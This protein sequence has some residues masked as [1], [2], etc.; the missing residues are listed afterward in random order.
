DVGRAAARDRA[1]ATSDKAPTLRPTRSPAVNVALL[2]R[3]GITD[4]EDL[5]E[6]RVHLR[7][8]TP[9]DTRNPAV[10]TEL[11][12][13]VRTLLFRIGIEQVDDMDPP[14]SCGMPQEL[15]PGAHSTAVLFLAGPDEQPENDDHEPGSIEGLLADL[16]PAAPDGLD[17]NRVCG[18]ALE[19]LLGALAV[20]PA[21]LEGR[22]RPR[23]FL[24]G[25]GTP[26]ETDV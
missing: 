21:V 2:S 4:P 17:P 5:F 26:R 1:W 6:L 15:T 9:H 8:G 20:D 3:P 13:K 19:S 24:G 23:R 7:T 12:D 25:R 18:T 16:E 14:R 22:T 11:T 10:I